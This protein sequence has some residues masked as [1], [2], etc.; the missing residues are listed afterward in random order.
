MDNGRERI[1]GNVELAITQLG[2]LSDV[3]FG[4]NQ[5]S[6]AWVDGFIE[7]QRARPDF[8][9][10]TVDTLISVLGSFLG[11][12]VVARTGGSWHETDDGTWVVLLPNG[13]TVFP[14]SKV[15]KQFRDGQEAGESIASFYHV[16]VTVVA[17]GSSNE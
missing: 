10:D 2:P 15:R 3:D 4:L 12:C 8:D 7:R 16:A 11:E 6:V 13:N 1:A 9:L 17:E 14:F 5:E